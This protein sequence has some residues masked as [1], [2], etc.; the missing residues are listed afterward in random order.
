MTSTP[1]TLKDGTT[2]EIDLFETLS[3]KDVFQPIVS[4]LDNSDQGFIW[5]LI[6]SDLL[7]WYATAPSHSIPSMLV[8]IGYH[9]RIGQDGNIY[10][11]SHI[12]AE[13]HKM[14]EVVEVLKNDNQ[15]KTDFWAEA[16]EW[17]FHDVTGEDIDLSNIA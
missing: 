17:F 11:F 6:G 13:W 15:G 14:D 2:V 1:Y 5:Y 9:A 8:G 3:G 4:K 12:V 7:A 10:D 16:R